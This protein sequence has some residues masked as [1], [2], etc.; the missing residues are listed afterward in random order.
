MS[1]LRIDHPC[2]A[3]W[4]AMTPVPGGRHC[5][6]CDLDVQD[7][8]ELAGPA[9]ST[10]TERITSAVAG[11]QRVCVRL[12]KAPSKA[13]R[14][15]LTAGM[16]ALLAMT[17]SGCQEQD[18]Q[19]SSLHSARQVE[20]N[21]DQKEPP[22]DLPTAAATIVEVVGEGTDRPT[23]ISELNIPLVKEELDQ[24]S[25]EEGTWRIMGGI[26]P[27][28]KVE[29]VTEPVAIPASDGKPKPIPN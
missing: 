22:S 9:L 5:S 4:A 24:R 19:V 26:C 6:A 1:D 20:P 7:L 25:I 28:M 16:A 23:P 13:R 2:T 3:N 8:S 18:S 15:I 27:Q 21:L 10:V 14:R 11:G 17:V 12:R 29:S